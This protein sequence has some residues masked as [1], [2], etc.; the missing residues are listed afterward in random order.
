MTKEQDYIS[1]VGEEREWRKQTLPLC[2]R[3]KE[4][5]NNLKKE[6]AGEH[7]IVSF[8]LISRGNTI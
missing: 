7:K 6:E 3:C 2:K 8:S 1:P 5:G 4:V